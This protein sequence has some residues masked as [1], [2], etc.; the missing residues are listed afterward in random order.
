MADDTERPQWTVALAASSA[1]FVVS[2]AVQRLLAAWSAGPD[3]MITP[4]SDGYIPYRW[5][6][7][8]AL[9]QALMVLF[10]A[11]PLLGEG[12]AGVLARWVPVWVP[13]LVTLSA[14]AMLA[15]P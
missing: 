7:A 2:Y 15:V 4:P 13:V 12:A 6:C 10:I 5:R 1:T 14:I 9:L 3:W 8:I 11:G